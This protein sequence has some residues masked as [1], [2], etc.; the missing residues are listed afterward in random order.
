MHTADHMILPG[1]SAAPTRF[2]FN[3]LVPCYHLLAPSSHP[4]IVFIPLPSTL[5]VTQSTPFPYQPKSP[6]H[7]TPKSSQSETQIA[8]ESLADA[9][10]THYLKSPLVHVAYV[11]H[12]PLLARPRSGPCPCWEGLRLVI[13][14][15]R[16]GFV[17]LLY[18]H[19]L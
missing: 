16:T 7:H 12:G 19:P 5:V 11:V 17:R 3:K 8:Q 4:H 9:S 13:E 1:Q 15:F 2:N 14:R 10:C 18:L 6:D